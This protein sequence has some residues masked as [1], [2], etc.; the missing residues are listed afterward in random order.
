MSDN[1]AI[2]ILLVEDSS[3]YREMVRAALV[4]AGYRVDAVA[5]G[6]EAIAR[7][8]DG[9]Y[10]VLLADTVLPDLPGIELL[11]RVRQIDPDQCIILMTAEGSGLSAAG[12]IRAGADDYLLKPM[13]LDDDGADLDVIIARSLE[14]RRLAREN[15][16][17]QAKLVEASKLNAVM[18]LAGAA[19]HEMNQPLT[20]ISGIT[21][22][23]LMDADPDDPSYADYEALQRA[24]Q[25]LCDIVGKLGAV[26]AYRTKPYV[27]DT[28]ILDLE[29]S[30]RHE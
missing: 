16:A 3:A 9:G 14:R 6:K 8:Q 21:E 29:R 30:A 10:D 18:S 17:L 7:Y 22:L 1:A 26:T 5:S 4:H 27:G 25:R 24:T 23:L 20:V 12:V 28:R 2:A 13:R 15:K 19:A 11:A